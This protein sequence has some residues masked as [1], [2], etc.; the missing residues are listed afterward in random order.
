MPVDLKMNGAPESNRG[1]LSPML[2][3]YTQVQA[4]SNYAVIIF[5]GD[6]INL[7]HSHAAGTIT[8]ASAKNEV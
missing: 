3:P 6:T 2:L 5:L 4:L 8:A 1:K 7:I